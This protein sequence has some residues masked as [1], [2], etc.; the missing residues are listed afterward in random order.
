MNGGNGTNTLEVVDNVVEPDYGMP[1]TGWLQATS[2]TA[3]AAHRPS[4]RCR[5]PIS[6]STAG[7]TTAARAPGTRRATLA[8][9]SSSSAAQD[10]SAKRLHRAATRATVSPSPAAQPPVVASTRTFRFRSAQ[11]RVSVPTPRLSPLVLDSG[12]E[13]T[14]SCG[15]SATRRA[16]PQGAFRAAAGQERL[17]PRLVVRDGARGALGDHGSS[18]TTP[19]TRPTLGIDAV[20]V[21]ESFVVQRRFRQ[22]RVVPAGTRR[23]IPGSGSSRPAGS[24]TS[25]TRATA[26]LSPTPRRLAAGI[27]QD[28]ALPIRAGDSLCADAEVVTAAPTPG[29]GAGWCSGCWASRGRRSPSSSFGRLAGQ[30]P[31]DRRL[32]LR[33]CDGPHSGFRIEFYDS[34]EGARARR[35]RR[36]CPPVLRGQRRLQ[37]PRQRRVA[38]G[39]DTWF[40]IEAAGKL[41]TRAPTRA[42]SFGASPPRDCRG[43]GIYQDVVA[44][45][46]APARA[47]APMPRW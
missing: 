17:E 29:L 8:V 20:D 46:S 44:C 32:D 1:V 15:C 47:S 9:P 40:A 39:A 11:A 24:D 45:R 23:G 28:V 26:S 37:Q 27:Y 14:M 3:A 36:R 42:T 33:D 2:P 7:S 6:S 30:E 10:R 31:L 22:P 12:A 34:R 19:P 38:Q 25:R 5:R 43:G 16:S 41:G 35:R 21:H 13:G 18:S 4:G